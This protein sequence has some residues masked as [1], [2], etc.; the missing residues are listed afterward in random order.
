MTED[1]ATKEG[2]EFGKVQF[3]FTHDL[4]LI[5]SITV[6]YVTPPAVI[7]IDAKARGLVNILPLFV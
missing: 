4:A 7:A 1:S 2:N 6:G 3:G 5:S